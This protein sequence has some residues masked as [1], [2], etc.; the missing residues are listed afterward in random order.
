MILDRLETLSAI[1]FLEPAIPKKAD[2]GRNCIFIRVDED[3]LILTAGNEYVVK[4]AI[5]IAQNTTEG[6][7]G[8]AQGRKLPDRFMIPRPELLAFKKLMEEDKAECKKLAKNDPSHLF[9]EIDDKELIS[10]KGK[11]DYEQ[12]TFLF[13][14]LEPVF[15]ITKSSVDEMPLMSGDA[16]A[17][18][19][20]F[21]DSQPVEVSFTGYKNPVHFEQ[22][23]FEALLIPPVEKE[24]EDGQKTIN[25]EE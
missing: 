1:S 17:A 12:P 18:L 13:K 24:G 19:K 9:V 7:G 11:I 14:E 6:A 20:G 10:F 2:S 5:L 3:K 21:L 15:S 4:K 25:D 16:R 8:K 22:G 23:D